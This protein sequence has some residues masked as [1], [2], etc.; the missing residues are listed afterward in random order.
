MSKKNKSLCKIAKNQ[1]GKYDKR[2][3]KVDEI[4]D[5][6]YFIFKESSLK[7]WKGIKIVPTALKCS[8]Y[9]S[10]QKQYFFVSIIHNN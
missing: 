8:N 10:K 2:V 5:K 7:C 9:E 6:D 3:Q 1:R 4:K